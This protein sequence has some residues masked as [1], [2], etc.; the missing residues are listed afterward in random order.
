ML[1]N[2][3]GFLSASGRNWLVARTLKHKFQ[4][5]AG[6]N[7]VLDHHTGAHPLVSKNPPFGW[8]GGPI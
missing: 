8:R 4:L 7:L 2:C 3:E 5:L 1:E 6:K